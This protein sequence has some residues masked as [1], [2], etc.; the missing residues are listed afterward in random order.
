MTM[1]K[2][3]VAAFALGAGIA[4]WTVASLPGQ[5]PAP[6]YDDCGECIADNPGGSINL[7]ASLGAV[8]VNGAID[9]R[10]ANGVVG[11]VNASSGGNVNISAGAGASVTGSIDTSGGVGGNGP[12]AAFGYGG[13]GGDAGDIN[14][15]GA[16]VTT[17]SITARGGAGGNGGTFN[18]SG[19]GEL[20]HTRKLRR[21]VIAERYADLIEAL[22][23]GRDSCRVHTEVTFEDGRKGRIEGELRIATCRTFDASE[24][25]A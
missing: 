20:T 6:Y 25:A 18:D 24:A 10:G 3:G 9:T 2:Y 11:Y 13:W 21:N 19:Y 4:A 22:Y 23:S 8:T 16:S 7:T 17:S 15:S 1:R 5:T 12:N 14:I